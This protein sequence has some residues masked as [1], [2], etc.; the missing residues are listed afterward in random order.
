[1]EDRALQPR[2]PVS[3]SL[4]S[5]ALTEAT[6]PVRSRPTEKA[7][8]AKN[9]SLLPSAGSVS[10]DVDPPARVSPSGETAA[11]ACGLSQQSPAELI[12]DS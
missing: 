12:P 7:H 3:R 4:G 2:Y 9:G 1:M 8:A 5:L 11:L 10:V 6:C